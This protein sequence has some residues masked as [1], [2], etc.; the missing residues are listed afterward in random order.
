MAVAHVRTEYFAATLD[1]AL[2][3]CRSGP[4]ECE[5]RQVALPGVDPGVLL[6]RLW[7]LAAGAS[8]RPAEF[9]A[10]DELVAIGDETRGPWT[11]RIRDSC[12]EAI[13]DIRDAQTTP[14]AVLWSRAPEWASPPRAAELAERLRQLRAVA[15]AA[16]APDRGMYAWVRL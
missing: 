16:V 15:R 5:V 11:V 13:A 10:D 12:T 6:G 1:Q 7:A 2:A 4:G 14:V 9:T 3:C 8:Y